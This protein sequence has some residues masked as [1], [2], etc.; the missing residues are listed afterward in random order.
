MFF[1]RVLQKATFPKI[2]LLFLVNNVYDVVLCELTKKVVRQFSSTQSVDCKTSELSSASLQLQ[3]GASLFTV[4]TRP[5]QNSQ[6]IC[7]IYSG[8]EEVDA[9]HEVPPT[10]WMIDSHWQ[11]STSMIDWLFRNA[12]RLT[13]TL[14]PAIM[15]DS[16][17][18]PTLAQ[19]LFFLF[20]PHSGW[21]LI[22][23]SPLLPDVT[24]R[25][26]HS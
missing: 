17:V 25:V 23:D 13:A 11:T 14:M 2:K 22:M 18:R 6:S 9:L 5:E 16:S 8:V 1:F 20:D 12:D 21:A 15:T 4:L 19:V 26:S 3:L 7:N 10:S 24:L